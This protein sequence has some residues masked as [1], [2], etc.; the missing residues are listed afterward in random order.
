MIDSEIQWEEVY[1]EFQTELV[2]KVIER[3]MEIVEDNLT[4][5]EDENEDGRFTYASLDEPNTIEQLKDYLIDN[6]T[7]EER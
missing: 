2:A 3:I 1:E 6:Y 5:E 7:L 4:I